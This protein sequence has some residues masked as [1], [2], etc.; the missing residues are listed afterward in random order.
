MADLKQRIAKRCAKEFK[1][2]DFINLGIGLPTMVAD[3][4]PDDI[5]V[6]CHS[7]NG[8]AGIDAVADETNT[9]VDIIN[10]GGVYVTALPRAKFF[11]TAESFGLVRGGHVKATVLGAME[12]AEN[13]DLANW[14]VPGKKVAGMGGAMDLC[15]GCPEVI[16]VM[17]HTQKGNHKILEKCTLP[18]T[19]EKCVSKIITEMGVME[20][21]EDGIWVTELHPDYS[22]ED[23]QAAT[24]C[25]LHFDPEMKPM[26]EE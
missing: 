8:F 6:T 10:S 22:R 16:I 9:D 17:L 5:A 11:D 13:G 23:I 12:V 20:V 2:G 18:L 1:D 4:I 26:E 14:I 7:E 3:Y 25:K 19:A 21:R 24:G 15:A